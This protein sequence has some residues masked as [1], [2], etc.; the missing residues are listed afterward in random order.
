MDRAQL[1]TAMMIIGGVLILVGIIGMPG[2]KVT[3]HSLLFDIPFF[4]GIAL[5]LV[6]RAW[7]R[8]T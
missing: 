3:I 7:R 8:A 2:D 4:A 1:G 6:G 5:L